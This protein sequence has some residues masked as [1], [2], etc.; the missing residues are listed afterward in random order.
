[1]VKRIADPDRGGGLPRG[2]D[3][4]VLDEAE[5]LAREA[6]RAGFRDLDAMVEGM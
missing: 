2:K 6:E 4:I 1:M 5:Y 3:T